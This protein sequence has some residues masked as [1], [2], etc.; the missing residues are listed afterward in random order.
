MNIRKRIAQLVATGLIIGTV[1]LGSA[2]AAVETPK[3]CDAEFVKA[4]I[5]G[6]NDDIS[7]ITDVQ[8]EGYGSY[9]KDD[10][11]PAYVGCRG[12]FTWKNGDQ[13]QEYFGY[14]VDPSIPKGSPNHFVVYW[15]HDHVDKSR[16]D[17]GPILAHDVKTT[18]EQHSNSSYSWGGGGLGGLALIWIIR[19]FTNGRRKPKE[20]QV[21][22]EI[23]R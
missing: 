3:L 9:S 14:Y 7:S 11:M 20:T 2:W 10:D 6:L 16:A 21:S 5:E 15:N 19:L 1:G 22:D 12:Q 13:A 8:D 17:S 23:A 4:A 18:H